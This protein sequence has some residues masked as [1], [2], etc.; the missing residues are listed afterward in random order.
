MSTEKKIEEINQSL[1][2]LIDSLRKTTEVIKTIEESV[3]KVHGMIK[4]MI[5]DI[6]KDE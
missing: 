5:E 6:K 4:D 2:R 1:E 3:G